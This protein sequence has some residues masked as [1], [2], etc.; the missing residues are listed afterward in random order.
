MLGWH[1]SVYRQA[2]R[3]AHPAPKDG[4]PD[5]PR[6]AVWQTDVDGADW[7]HEL[8]AESRAIQLRHDGYPNRYTSLAKYLTPRIV[9]GPPRARSVWTFSAGDIIT[10]KWAGKTILDYSVIEACSPTEWLLVEAWDES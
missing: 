7:I 4:E 6:L 9:G 5:G 3:R 1:I 10:D 2:G 8:V